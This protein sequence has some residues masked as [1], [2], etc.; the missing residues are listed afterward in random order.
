MTSYRI[1]QSGQVIHFLPPV[2]EHFER[3]QQRRLFDREAGG[4][5]FATFS[6][7]V[8]T[9]VEATGPRRRDRRSRYSYVPDRSAEQTEI[10]KRYPSGLNFIGDWHTHPAA[11]PC[12]SPQDL[13]SIGDTVRR[14]RHVLN[15]FLLVVIGTG[16]LPENMYVGIHDGVSQFELSCA[17]EEL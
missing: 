8:F 12:P 5:L 6:T 3:N 7:D 15:G 10:I 4:Q 14:S 9:V 17:N 2:M 11:F 16:P 1:G 13:S